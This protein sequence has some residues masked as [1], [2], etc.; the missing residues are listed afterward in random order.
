MSCL[1]KQELII[2]NRL[3][4]VSRW[5]E[6]KLLL[7]PHNYFI[8]G[9]QRQT[10]TNSA[11]LNYNPTYRLRS[12]NRT[13]LKLFLVAVLDTVHVKNLHLQKSRFVESRLLFSNSERFGLVE[14]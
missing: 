2:R 14:M 8:N 13:N 4:K 5:P 1:N 9:Q 10:T 7:I 3:W 6:E 12:P 11:D